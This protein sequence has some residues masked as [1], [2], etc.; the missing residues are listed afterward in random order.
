MYKIPKTLNSKYEFVTLAAKRAEQLQMGA[1]PRVTERGG[2]KATIMAQEEVA[3]GLV[4]TWNP[5]DDIE[6]LEELEEEE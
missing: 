1:A 5:E 6:L 4:S 2:R 3:L